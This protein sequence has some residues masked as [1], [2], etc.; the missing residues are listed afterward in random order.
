[1]GQ[2][3]AKLEQ[4]RAALKHSPVPM[5]NMMAAAGMQYHMQGGQMYLGSMRT[6]MMGQMPMGA[7]QMRGPAQQQ[8]YRGQP[9][10]QM[11]QQR[12]GNPRN[13]RVPRAVPQQQGQR[14]QQ[15]RNNNSQ[16]QQPAPQ[17]AKQ[18]QQAKQLTLREQVMAMEPA[19][20]KNH[21][22]EQLYHQIATVMPEHAPK[23]TGML[24]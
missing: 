10:M 9:N 14:Q 18:Q 21:L 8:S 4:E 7:P 23:I 19:A 1:M 24:L 2:R 12:A 15:A 16:Q 11:Q 3:K 13:N 22:G 20:Q 5:N 17:Q 6:P